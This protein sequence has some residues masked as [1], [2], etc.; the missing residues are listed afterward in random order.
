MPNQNTEK[1]FGYPQHE[2][3]EDAF[4][5]PKNKPPEESESIYGRI[6]RLYNSLNIRQYFVTN[7]KH[8]LLEEQYL[9]EQEKFAQTRL[10]KSRASYDIDETQLELENLACSRWHQQQLAE[11]Y[12]LFRQ[13][14]AMAYTEDGKF[15]Q[16][17]DIADIK[18][19]GLDPNR[20]E[21]LI[22]NV[23]M[24]MQPKPENPLESLRQCRFDKESI[25][26]SADSLKKYQ[27]D[28]K[29]CQKNLKDYQTDCIPKT[30]EIPKLPVFVLLIQELLNYLFDCLT[31]PIKIAHEDFFVWKLFEKPKDPTI[32]VLLSLIVWFTLL[33]YLPKIIKSTIDVIEVY[34]EKQKQKQKQKQGDK[35]SFSLPFINFRGGFLA[36][37][38]DPFF[39]YIKTIRTIQKVEL[40][41]PIIPTGKSLSTFDKIKKIKLSSEFI[42]FL[43]STAVGAYISAKV[44]QDSIDRPVKT[45]SPISFRTDVP[46]RVISRDFVIEAE[47]ITPIKQESEQDQL[48]ERE[49][50]QIIKDQKKSIQERAREKRQK[51]KSRVGYFKDYQTNSF[52]NDDL[53]SVENCKQFENEKIR[54]KNSN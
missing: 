27:K 12:K 34:K 41:D 47:K 30:G 43:L 13:H 54:I 9:R 31:W 32:L 36:Q 4:Q 38:V 42:Y 23:F 48:K 29:N 52:E 15:I 19:S 33:G 14:S 6:Q 25:H 21:S 51:Q 10:E 35:P 26:R 50:E 22:T 17:P 44:F 39:L 45:Y 46:E 24:E 8:G 40:L 16:P 3:I 20:L 11:R 1:Y 7:K 18:G 28:L 49:S 5:Y 2:D 37:P 53:N